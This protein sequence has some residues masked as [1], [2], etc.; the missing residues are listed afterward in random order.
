MI[1][2]CPEKENNKL[3]RIKKNNKP[4]A[5][6]NNKHFLSSTKNFNW[7]NVH[8]I[9]LFCGKPFRKPLKCLESQIVP[10][11]LTPPTKEEIILP[12]FVAVN[13]AF[14]NFS[15]CFLVK[16]IGKNYFTVNSVFKAVYDYAAKG[17]ERLVCDV[18]H[19]FKTSI[20]KYIKFK[21][22]N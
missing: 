21:N 19:F 11:I 12:V 6:S 5:H 18:F 7:A 3:N 14:V 15:D 17:V 1:G 22:F 2:H 9:G 4:D 8:G 10:Q 20:K 16:L 13:L